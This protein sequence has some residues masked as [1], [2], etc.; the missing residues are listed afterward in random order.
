[1]L[2]LP[3]SVNNALLTTE[4]SMNFDQFRNLS[5]ALFGQTAEA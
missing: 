4:L 5:P 2:A 1:M 3:Y